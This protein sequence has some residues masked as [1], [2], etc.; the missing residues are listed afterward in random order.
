MQWAKC[1]PTFFDGFNSDPQGVAPENCNVLVRSGGKALGGSRTVH[2]L[3][4]GKDQPWVAVC[5]DVLNDELIA[6]GLVSDARSVFNGATATR[7]SPGLPRNLQRPESV[8]RRRLQ[9]A[10][11]GGAGAALYCQGA[12]GRRLQ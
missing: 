5:S 8:A 1:R 7:S 6:S 10:D 4:P 2:E 12:R 9:P 11:L 3:R